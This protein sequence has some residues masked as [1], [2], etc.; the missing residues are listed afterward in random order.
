MS[1]YFSEEEK[2]NTLIGEQIQN[3]SILF[4]SLFIVLKIITKNIKVN[5]LYYV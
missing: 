5:L 2:H 3:V 1:L 4:I